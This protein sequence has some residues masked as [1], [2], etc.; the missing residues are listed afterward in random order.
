MT[1]SEARRKKLKPQTPENLAKIDNAL[2]EAF[3]SKNNLFALKILFYIAKMKIELDIK[4]LELQTITLNV[5]NTLEYCKIDIRTLKRNIK[6]MT[7]T[8]ISF[9]DKKEDITEYISILPY[10]K[11]YKNNIEIKMFKKII[12]LIAELKNKF[13]IIDL[14]NLMQLESKHSV[15]MVQLLEYIRGFS[16]SDTVAE[17]DKKVSIP[18]RK[19]YLLEDLNGMFGV[20]YKRFADFERKILK[21]VKEELD[22]KSDLSFLYQLEE[23]KTVSQGR[24]KHIAVTIDLVDNIKR[25]RRF[26]F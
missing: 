15:R 3:V 17:T 2:I 11:I 10:A 12:M 1:P 16:S 26:I 4:E 25:Q 24:K 20:D 14:D 23:D 6:Q 18:K 21:P 13:T 9:V 7:E 5:D 8:S 19:R 22:D